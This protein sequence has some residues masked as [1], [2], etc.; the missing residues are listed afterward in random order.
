VRHHKDYTYDANGNRETEANEEADTTK[1]AYDD[2]NR[3]W[4]VFDPRYVESGTKWTEYVYDKVGNK[5][6]QIDLNGH[7]T[8]FYYDATN[9]LVKTYY[10]DNPPDD[11]E[12]PG[13]VA[14]VEEVYDQAGNRVERKTKNGDEQDT[15]TYTYD[16]RNRLE[17]IRYPG[18]PAADVTYIYDLAGNRLS[19]DDEHGTTTYEYD[20]R[21]RLTK[22]TK[23]QGW[24]LEYD[25]DL[26]GNKVEFTL[27]VNSTVNVTTYAYDEANR[28]R[29]VVDPEEGQSSY[30]Y[31]KVG[32][33]TSL[34]YPNGVVADCV[35]DA[36][37]R[38]TDLHNHAGETTIS[39]HRY[40]HHP[41]GNR[42]TLTDQDDRVTTYLYDTL[43][44]LQEE[45]QVAA[46]GGTLYDHK[47]V[48]DDV[49]NLL[50]KLD[51][52]TSPA[53]L[54]TELTYNAA[55][56]ISSTGFDYD[57]RGNMLSEHRPEAED[58][59]WTYEYD[60]QNRLTH[61]YNGTDNFYYEYDGDGH[62]VKQTVNLIVTE[63]VVDLNGG[64]SQVV[65]DI[66]SGGNLKVLYVRG[67]DLLSQLQSSA[68]HWYSY[69]G[70]GST[71]AL[72]D[73]AGEQA[74]F[75][76]YDAWGNRLDT[77]EHPL[78]RFRYTGQEED[79]TGLYY[80]RA[81]YYG[82]RIGR[83][84]GR[85]PWVGSPQEPMTLHIYCYCRTNPVGGR[86]PSGASDGMTL[87]QMLFA[88]AI[89]MALLQLEATIA[90][91]TIGNFVLLALCVLPLLNLEAGGASRLAVV[92]AK[93]GRGT[94]LVDTA[95]MSA[96][97]RQVVRVLE[98]EGV[99]TFAYGNKIR[100]LLHLWD[101]PVVNVLNEWGAGK[102]I[103]DFWSVS[104]EG[105]LVFTELC[106]G[107]ERS[108]LGWYELAQIREPVERAA[109]LYPGQSVAANNIFVTNEAI[110]TEGFSDGYKVLGGA[111][112]GQLVTNTGA[113]AE[114][115]GRPVVVRLLGR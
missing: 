82:P 45:K 43:N 69:D 87:G 108:A 24:V 98:S 100:P 107:S 3:L 83:F 29:T 99:Q 84:A 31:D 63:F 20:E 16:E 104:S 15:T 12:D 9:R 25:Y 47:F 95:A 32:N 54:L 51:L 93:L 5:L 1:W 13:N 106:E 55:D 49:G 79:D 6:K 78:N 77:E 52:T 76:E 44:R 102:K 92:L 37:N 115:G 112:G 109:Y 27:T 73:D 40:T 42:A 18:S 66:N 111:S 19:M 39:R 57:D 64:L 17:T 80:L 97:E 105:G 36:R 28:L 89:I 88:L 38:L 71:I 70:H 101:E 114:A 67:D 110:L 61:A 85:D 72:T 53:T 56:Q 7:T 96:T 22:E 75:Y 48:Y 65:A 60:S 26:A 58:E 30:T 35:Y 8:W 50:Q 10:P 23:A 90:R 41:D 2:A 21:N 113:L 68:W 62:R 81:R 14:S 59:D 74:D 11:E 103:M 94:E 46:G 86:D 33:R 4:K 34:S 91:P